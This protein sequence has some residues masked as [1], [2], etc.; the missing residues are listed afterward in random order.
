MKGSFIYDKV[1]SDLITYLD[2]I[3]PIQGKIANA[4]ERELDFKLYYDP[5]VYNAQIPEQ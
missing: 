2:F 5:A 1:T 4:A 3:D